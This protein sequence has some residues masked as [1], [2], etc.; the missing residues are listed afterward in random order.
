MHIGIW[1]YNTDYAMRSDE[2][3]K[4]CESRGF[5]SFWVPEHTHLPARL[6]TPIPN[7]PGYEH[8][9]LHMV[10]PFVSL[11]AVAA[12]TTTLK[13]GTGVCLVP[14][15]DPIILAKTIATLDLFSAGRLLFGI[16]AGWIE[17]EMVNHH[18]SFSRRWSVMHE[19]IEA[20][21]AIWTQEEASY[22]GE[23]VQFEHVRS[24]P[25]PLQKPHPPILI[26]SNTPQGRQRTVHYGNIWGPIDVP[27]EELA[28]TIADLSQRAEAAGRD[29][30]EISVT[31]FTWH[32]LTLDRAERY[33]DIGLERLVIVYPETEPLEFLD[34]MAE[35]I[36]KVK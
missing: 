32:P 28:A 34:R 31:M 15:H 25:K 36:L 1:S 2:L 14:E 20:M 11:M 17:E 9:L 30:A 35:F 3:A 23:F 27:L 4:V 13:I 6:K 10:D 29:P 21:Q 22:D 33:R 16:G 24:Y 8:A 18:K 26:G 12:V 5:E 19:H 7:I